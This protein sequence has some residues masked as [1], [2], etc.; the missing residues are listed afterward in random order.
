MGL[1]GGERDRDFDNGDELMPEGGGV[2]G[3]SH[4]GEVEGGDAHAEGAEDRFARGG[5]RFGVVRHEARAGGIMTEGPHVGM[6][7]RLR[8]RAERKA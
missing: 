7:G 6:I 1:G 5:Y 8:V 4:G 2:G 3:I